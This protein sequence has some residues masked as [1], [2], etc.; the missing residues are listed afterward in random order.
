[1]VAG[2]EV[3]HYLIKV[4]PFRTAARQGSWLKAVKP[5]TSLR[6]LRPAKS[7]RGFGQGKSLNGLEIL[8]FSLALPLPQALFRNALK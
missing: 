4:I 6:S 8:A 3:S 2:K 7:L 1:M 5:K